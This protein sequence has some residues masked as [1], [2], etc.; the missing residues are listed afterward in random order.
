MGIPQLVFNFEAVSEAIISEPFA[1]LTRLVLRRG[2]FGPP[3]SVRSPVT[4]SS[5]LAS[6]LFTDDGMLRR[7][8]S[9]AEPC[10]LSRAQSGSSEYVVTTK[11]L[12]FE[13]PPLEILES[14]GME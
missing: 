3:L 11:G 9:A 12:F 1:S 10:V 8:F 6:G 7:L 13:L 5:S 4:R 14:F 2:A